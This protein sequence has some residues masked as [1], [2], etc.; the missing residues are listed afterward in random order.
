MNKPQFSA[1]IEARLTALF[2]AAEQGRDIAP[3][4]RF[5]LEG[6]IEAGC[7]LGWVTVAEVN[8]LIVRL[9][10]E[11]HQTPAPE[12]PDD[13][14]VIPVVMQRAPVYPSTSE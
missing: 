13:E 7:C 9:W 14:V 12:L 3:A 4:T 5:R 11:Y 1:A 10:G 8:A 2:K 6:F